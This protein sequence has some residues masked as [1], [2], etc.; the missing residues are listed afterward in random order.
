MINEEYLLGMTDDWFVLY[1]LPKEE[2]VVVPPEKVISL[3]MQT[4]K[5]KRVY[6][7]QLIIVLILKKNEGAGEKNVE[8]TIS[9]AKVESIGEN[10]EKVEL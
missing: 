7:K 10:S 8:S 1:Y 3:S 9:A 2:W 6:M 4:H 5:T